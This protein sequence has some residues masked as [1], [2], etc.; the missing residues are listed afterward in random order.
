MVLQ[1]IGTI[2]QLGWGNI[3]AL[4]KPLETPHT[5]T[6]QSDDQSGAGMKEGYLGGQGTKVLLI[7]TTG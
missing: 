4:W 2:H 1:L 6:S 3:P 5:A 7:L